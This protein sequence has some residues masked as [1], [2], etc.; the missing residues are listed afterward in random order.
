MEKLNNGGSLV[1]GD[2]MARHPNWDTRHVVRS[3][4]MVKQETQN[5]GKISSVNNPTWSTSIR[6]YTSDTFMSKGVGICRVRHT[7]E[8]E[9]SQ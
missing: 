4:K 6:N 9:R 5:N 2:I 8:K 7:N 3:G 1:V